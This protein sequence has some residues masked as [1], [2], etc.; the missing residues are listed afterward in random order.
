MEFLRPVTLQ[1]VNPQCDSG[2]AQAQK[3]RCQLG[4]RTAIC[5]DGV[6]GIRP[7]LKLRDLDRRK[8]FGSLEVVPVA[9][10]DENFP[11]LTEVGS[12]VIDYTFDGTPEEEDGYHVIFPEGLTRP[13]RNSYGT[14]AKNYFSDCPLGAVDVAI[15]TNR[16]EPHISWLV[17]I[18]F[19]FQLSRPIFKRGY[20]NPFPQYRG[21]RF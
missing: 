4:C 5:H 1:V 18:L 7:R 21:V 2:S 13:P 17:S 3:H 16:L 8:T 11:E 19:E 9:R 6:F 10:N 20:R 15:D 12:S 14:P